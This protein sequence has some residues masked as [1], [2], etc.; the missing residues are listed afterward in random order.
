MAFLLKAFLLTAPLLVALD[1]PAYH[2][3]VDLERE[4]VDVIIEGLRDF[5]NPYF[6]NQKS[7]HF[8]V[9]L[10]NEKNEVVGG[11]LA[12]MRPGIKLLYIDS[13]WISDPMRKK[14][15]GKKLMLA[16]EAEGKKNGCTHSQVDTLSFQAEPFYQK[17][18]YKRI[19]IVPKLY[20]EHDAIFMRKNLVE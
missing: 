10:K 4:Q 8:A 11:V 2:I 18:G 20:G 15:Y 17:L 12:W 13:I 7:I 9:Y 6:G 3:E 14:G 19:G 5:N 16:A 1:K